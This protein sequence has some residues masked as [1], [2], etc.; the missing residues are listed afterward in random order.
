MGI[1]EL[2]ISLPPMG[3]ETDQIDHKEIHWQDEALGGAWPAVASRRAYWLLAV[4][5]VQTQSRERPPQRHRA[6][7][8]LSS[9]RQEE[10]S[11]AQEQ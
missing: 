7:L 4:C 9:Q 11:L 2:R 10:E 1:D 3:I 6:I 5:C 8:I